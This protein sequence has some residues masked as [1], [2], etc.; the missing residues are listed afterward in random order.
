[1]KLSEVTPVTHSIPFPTVSNKKKSNVAEKLIKK[2][3]VNL[4]NPKV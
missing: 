2:I 1:M 4:K 3:I